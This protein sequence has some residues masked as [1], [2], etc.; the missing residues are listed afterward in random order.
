MAEYEFISQLGNQKIR[1]FGSTSLI[2]DLETGNLF[3]EKNHR[4]T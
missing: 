4:Q 2:K 3:V 1:K